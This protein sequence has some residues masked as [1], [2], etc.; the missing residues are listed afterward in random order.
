ML[1]LSSIIIFANIASA[2]EN[3]A[4]ALI[5]QDFSKRSV[6]AGVCQLKRGN[7]RKRPWIPVVHILAQQNGQDRRIP[8]HG[9]FENTEML[10]T[11]G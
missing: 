11:F 7:Y 4:A 1:I 10:T 8:L 5:P 9:N 3:E 6:H 2:I